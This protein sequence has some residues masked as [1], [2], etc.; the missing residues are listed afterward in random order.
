MTWDVLASLRAESLAGTSVRLVTADWKSALEK[1]WIELDRQDWDRIR[2]IAL[3]GFEWHDFAL[4]YYWTSDIGR[5]LDPHG[6]VI[7]HAK[8]HRAVFAG[9]AVTDH[10][11][12]MLQQT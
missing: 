8:T 6:N 2:P 4:R 10:L 11:A 5:L 1:V 7:A 12:S 3:N 9:N